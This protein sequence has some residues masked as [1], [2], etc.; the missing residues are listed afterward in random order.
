MGNPHFDLIVIGTGPSASTVA[1]KC[2]Q[3]GKRVAIIEAREFGGTCALRGC[4]PKKVYSNAANLID[5]IRGAEGKLVKCDDARIDWK[6]LVAFQR[7]F[8]QPV[9]DSTEASYRK[10]GIDTFHGRA[11]FTGRNSIEVDGQSLDADRIFVGVGA[12]PSPL[13]IPGGKRAIRS[14]EFFELTEIPKRVVFIG[15]GYISMEF[16]CVVARHGASVTVL[17]RTDQVL[18]EFDPDLVDQLT[19]Y[20]AEHGINIFTSTAVTEIDAASGGTMVVQYKSEGHMKS[21]E[22]DL[23]VHGAGRI[24][25]LDGLNLEAGEVTYSEMGI[26]VDAFMRS[27]SNPAVYAAGDCVDSSQPP[28]TPTA[29]EQ[30]R[31]VVN[32]LLATTPTH[33]PDYGVIPQ[34]AF[35]VPAIASIG[36]SQLDAERSHDAEIRHDDSSTWGSVRKTGQRCAG[37]KVI[38][39]RDSDLILGAHLLGPAAEETINLFALAMKHG[40]TSR[41][42]KS[43]LFAFPTF[44]S[45]VR[46]MV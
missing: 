12:R 41:D 15:G 11:S 16:A 19:E 10:Q 36:L 22:T 18:P 38:I 44:A 26:K 13:D 30:A 17:Q 37:Y 1:K 45:D 46:R 21:V 42:I 5:R 24:P 8:T 20:S 32:N 43:T 33:Q 39:D 34:V 40:L 31:A 7:E 35:T 23:V 25:N 29:N 9:A 27:T 2:R 6:E 14:D 28:L 3:E 4:N